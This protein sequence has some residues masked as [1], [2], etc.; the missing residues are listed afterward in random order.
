MTVAFT[1]VKLAQ[2]PEKQAKL[3][4]EVDAVLGDGKELLTPKHMADLKFTK[5][6]VKETLR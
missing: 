1:L 3:H 4:E 5:A 6:C 2:N